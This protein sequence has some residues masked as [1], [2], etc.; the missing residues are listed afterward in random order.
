LWA[1]AA[2]IAKRGGEGEG[3][4]ENEEEAEGDDDEDSAISMVVDRNLFEKVMA[5]EEEKARE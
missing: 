1:R 3:E 5:E 4:E 2:G